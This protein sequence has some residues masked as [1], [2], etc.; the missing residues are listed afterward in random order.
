MK[1][2]V[3]LSLLAFAGHSRS[4]PQPG[5]NGRCPQNQVFKSCGSACPTNCNTLDDFVICT[6]QCVSGCF[7]DEDNGYVL[8]RENG[9][10]CVLRESCGQC[11]DE[12]STF[13][14]CGTA[15]PR[16]CANPNP[17]F[18]TF[19]CVSEC[20]CNDGF[21]L[22]EDTE[23]CVRLDECPKEEQCEDEN[24]TFNQCGTACPPTCE[25]PTPGI[26]TKQCV[27]EC[28]C[29]KGYVLDESTG[30]CVRKDQCGSKTCDDP[31]AV[32][33]ECGTACP[34]TCDTPFPE[35]CTDNCVSEC[36]CKP[37]FVLN[38]QGICV[39]LRMCKIGRKCEDPNAIFKQCGTACPPTCEEPKTLKCTKNCV[40]ECQCKDGY[41]LDSEGTCVLEEEC[42]VECEDPNAVFMEC[43]T[44]CPGTCD[45]PNPKVCTEQCVS[46][47]QC[48]EGFVLNE[49]GLCVTKK[50][51]DPGFKCKGL[52]KKECKGTDGCFFKNKCKADTCEN[53]SK[54][55][56]CKASDKC[57]YDKK[58]K[59]CLD[60]I[61]PNRSKKKDCRKG[62]N[63]VW[64]GRRCADAK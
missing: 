52:E 61:C 26:C 4:E 11:E 49:S 47:C 24:A 58:S 3:I 32:F 53:R 31:N 18:C 27:A 14:E 41:V 23:E 36:Q 50:E 64:D 7:C 16:T 63:C 62:N 6:R 54:K 13:L 44:A 22:N 8:N 55:K 46:E 60:N 21:V 19:N 5:K 45:N 59:A 10:G 15:C 35:I 48:K 40:A 30:T 34:G 9:Y 17:Q 2:A 20:Q 42:P 1:L 37:G 51:C 25:N 43:G 12:N 29:N 57:F 38:D 33:M 56:L 39:N 28:Q